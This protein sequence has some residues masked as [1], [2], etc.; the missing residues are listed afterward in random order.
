[1]PEHRGERTYGAGLLARGFAITSLASKETAGSAV[2]FCLTEKAGSMLF[3]HVAK[4]RM[5]G[6]SPVCSSGLKPRKQT[7]P[8]RPFCIALPLHGL[9]E[10]RHS[11]HS[12]ATR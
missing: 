11:G 10:A 7:R 12:G 2:V 8:L 5:R 4:E 3:T 1:M 9:D 6:P